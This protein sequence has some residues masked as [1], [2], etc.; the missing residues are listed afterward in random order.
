M[1]F[2]GIGRSR[3]L[4]QRNSGARSAG[5]WRR[6]RL[7]SKRIQLWSCGGGRQSAGIAAMIVQGKLPKPDHV[8][9]THLEWEMGEVWPYV[10][11][12]IEPAML[13]LGVPFTAIERAHYA[14]HGFW[15]GSNGL[16]P[17]LP[18]Y[19]NQSGKASKLSE[20]CSGEWK[21]DV[22]MRWAAQQ[23]DWKERGVDNWVGISVDEARRRRAPRR[24][25][26]QPVYPLLDMHRATV[27]ECLT[28]VRAVGW[29]EPPRSRCYHCPNQSDAEWAELTPEEFEKACRT[30]EAIR[31]VDP[32]AY[33][34]K[35]L[36]PLRRVALDTADDNGGLFGGCS[37][38][39]CY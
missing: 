22:V 16:I 30:D 28:A 1:S 8:C 4:S 2:S 5:N 13:A 23:P 21:R 34:H 12:H 24:V 35:K 17:L 7:M 29:P 26:I 37:S 20:Y 33:L 36:I 11:A 3:N 9:M 15:G 19:K 27:S 31:M 32:H 38:G 10:R 25:W 6:P 14:T 18:V 39:T